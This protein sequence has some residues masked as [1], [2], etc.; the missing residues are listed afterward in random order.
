MKMMGVVIFTILNVTGDS[1]SYEVAMQQVEKE[2]EEE[3]EE[4]KNKR[5]QETFEHSAEEDS[6]SICVKRGE[7]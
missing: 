1:S 6:T 2:E 7:K 5:Q 4:L 3:E